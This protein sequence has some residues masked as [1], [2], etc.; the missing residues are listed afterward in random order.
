MSIHLAVVPYDEEAEEVVVGC[1]IASEHGAAL[2]SGRLAADDFYTP[3]LRR[4]FE[5]A[6]DLIGVESEADRIAFAAARAG[7]PEEDVRLLVRTRPVMHDSS[8]SFACRVREAARRRGVM[9]AATDAL[10]RLR[11]GEPLAEVLPILE[12]A[13]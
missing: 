1:A 4:L 6:T 12:G 9:L 13:L 3:R 7:V 10:E 5:A 8:G 2:A 11:R